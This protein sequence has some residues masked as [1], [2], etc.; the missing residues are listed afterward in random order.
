MLYNFIFTDVST[1]SHLPWHCKAYSKWVPYNPSFVSSC[2]TIWV[3]GWI[4]TTFQYNK[5]RHK[6]H[7]TLQPADISLHHILSQMFVHTTQKIKITENE[8]QNELVTVWCSYYINIILNLF[9]CIIQNFNTL[10][11]VLLWWN[12]G[13]SA[14]ET[15]VGHTILCY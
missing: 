6:M 15:C 10:R 9:T 5:P 12:W 8:Q 3:L 4:N 14:P 11:L 1:H 2:I 7:C 13:W